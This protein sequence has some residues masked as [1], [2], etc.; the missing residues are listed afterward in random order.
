MAVATNARIAEV[1]VGAVDDAV[2]LVTSGHRTECLGYD[3]PA[4][5]ILS[6]GSSTNE[7]HH[8]V[9]ISSFCDESSGIA[10]HLKGLPQFSA[11]PAMEEFRNCFVRDA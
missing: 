11:F 1:Q 4:F 9:F 6:G 2:W 10:T 8:F 5:R 7:R 3:Q